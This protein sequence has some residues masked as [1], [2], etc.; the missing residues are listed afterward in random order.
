MSAFFHGHLS[1][2]RI[3]AALE[4][5]MSLGAIQ[6]SSQP[7][8]GRPSTLWS[9]TVETQSMGGE[10]TADESTTEDTIK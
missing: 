10:E 5:L 4:Q 1:S 8:S 7:S 3:E 2:D 9:A 6:Q